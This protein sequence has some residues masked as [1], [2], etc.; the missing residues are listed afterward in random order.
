MGFSGS[1]WWREKWAWENVKNVISTLPGRLGFSEG[2]ELRFFRLRL[3]LA[4]GSVYDEILER[5]LTDREKYGLYFILTQYAKAEKDV[6]EY[7]EP[8]PLTRICPAIH[9]PLLKRNTKAFEVVFGYEPELLYKA[10][11]SFEYI[12]VDY[13]DAAVKIYVLPRVPIT[14]GVW[15]GEEGIPPSTTILFDKS[16]TNYLDCEAA[17]TLAG[18][19]LA[20]LIISLSKRGASLGKVDYKYCYACSEG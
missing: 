14:I 20:R 10:A 8:L 6:G 3:S 19:S 5:Y 4:D 16:I 15:A 12:P 7:N 11:E 9:C 18:A 17:T 1:S 2:N 13:G